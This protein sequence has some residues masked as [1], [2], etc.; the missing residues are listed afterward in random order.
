MGTRA[1]YML[2]ACL[3]LRRK[4]EAPCVHEANGSQCQ[5]KCSDNDKSSRHTC[6]YDRGQG[7]VHAHGMS[8]AEEEERGPIRPQTTRQPMPRE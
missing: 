1:V 3:E 6:M 4:R 7:C 2:M 8:I 5:G